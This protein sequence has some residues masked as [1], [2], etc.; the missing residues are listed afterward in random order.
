MSTSLLL[1]NV[2]W[3]IGRE[4]WSP[5]IDRCDKTVAHSGVVFE[6]RLAPD[7]SQRVVARLPV[8]RYP[9]AAAAVARVRTR[10]HSGVPRR[11]NAATPE[12]VFR[13]RGTFCR[14]PRGALLES[15]S[16]HGGVG[17]C[18]ISGAGLS[19]GHDSESEAVPAFYAHGL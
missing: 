11:P 9:S 6:T 4:R 3:D 5:E 1:R 2:H 10:P 8:A 15:P 17:V 13:C 18:A 7:L 16:G 14:V 12:H 19:V